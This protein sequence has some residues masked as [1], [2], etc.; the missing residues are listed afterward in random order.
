MSN[1]EKLPVVLEMAEQYK[2]TGPS[3]VHT[4]KQVA[5]EGKIKDTELLSCLMVAK[6]H[7][8]NP[9]TKEIYFMKTKAGAIQPIVSVDGWIKKCNSHPEFD[10]MEFSDTVDDEGKLVSIT[11]KIYRKDRGRPTVVTEY[12]E[13]CKGNT[14]P[15]K[16]HPSRMLRHR[17]L[18]QCARI[19]FGFSGVMDPDEFK[20]WQD[21]IKDVTPATD[22]PSFDE[23]EAEMT[24]EPE[25]E[26][27]EGKTIDL[28]EYL[29]D[30]GGVL[31]VDGSMVTF[32][33]AVSH[34][35]Q[36]VAICADLESLNEVLEQWD[37]VIQRL[38]RKQSEEV[39]GLFENAKTRIEQGEEAA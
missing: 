10:G 39:E 9:L 29:A 11:C 26:D 23:I 36:E 8:L 20:T 31:E 30:H 12:M 15:W 4:F 25:V 37:H 32:D 16:S 17:A 28:E 3:L 7:K 19:A 1:I 35:E 27:V 6:E 14:G 33:V 13:E 22:A 18:I 5:A 24:A 2:L 34:I 21:G 38:P